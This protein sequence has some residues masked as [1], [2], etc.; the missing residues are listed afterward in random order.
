MVRTIVKHG[1]DAHDRVRRHR[2]FQHGILQPFFYRREIVFGDGAAYYL[3]LKL[4]S[5]L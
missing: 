3:L 5:C 2:A 4:K 1:F